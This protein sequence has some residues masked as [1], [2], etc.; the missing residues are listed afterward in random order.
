MSTTIII[1]HSI[2][3]IIIIQP[4]LTKYAI[5][6]IIV[7]HKLTS[8]FNAQISQLYR[9]QFKDLHHVQYHYCYPFHHCCYCHNYH[10]TSTHKMCFQPHHW[11]IFTSTSTTITIIIFITV[12]IIIIITII[13]LSR[14]RPAFAV[15][16]TDRFPDP[17]GRFEHLDCVETV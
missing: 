15:H 11:I 10:S 13:I 1:I 6:N 2:I 8:V 5:T 12:I 3:T 16:G 17:S 9:G 4:R 14:S 7:I